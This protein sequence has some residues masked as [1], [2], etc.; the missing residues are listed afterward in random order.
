MTDMIQPPGCNYQLMSQSKHDMNLT[1]SG[2]N[3]RPFSIDLPS[4]NI[5]TPP[6][7]LPLQHVSMLN[8]II[9]V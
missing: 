5:I 9:A 8:L 2:V 3:F 1:F 4:A 6:L 7:P